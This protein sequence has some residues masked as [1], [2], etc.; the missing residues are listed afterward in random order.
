M[1][2][3]Y[4]LRTYVA[5]GVI[6]YGA[7]DI[8]KLHMHI[9]C[10][11]LTEFIINGLNWFRLSPNVDHNLLTFIKGNIFKMNTGI[12]DQNIQYLLNKCFTASLVRP[13]KLKASP[14]VI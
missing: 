10:F 1:F 12:F 3:K 11:A 14:I 7:R 2:C 13:L 8:N 4:A 6:G 5:H 9:Y